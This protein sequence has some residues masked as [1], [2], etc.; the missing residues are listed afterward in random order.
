M[1][2]GI[3]AG[4]LWDTRES[5]AGH[6]RNDDVEGILRLPAERG[7]I[8]Q[9]ADDLQL[10]DDRPRPAVRDDER[11]RVLLFRAN[12]NEMNVQPVDLRDELWQGA[13]PGLALAPV[14]FAGPILR[15]VLHGL[16]L[17]ALRRVV[18]RL[19]FRPAGRLDA[20][21]K[22][23]QRLFRSLEMKRT[24]RIRPRQLVQIRC[25][26]AFGRLGG[27]GGRTLCVAGGNQK[28]DRDECACA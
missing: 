1:W 20:P 23:C 2:G 19:S 25:N 16:E 24:N 14:V 26:R 28:H 5:V 21:A 9:R 8:G 27:V 3:P 18:D 10:L 22:I 4:F 15:Q 12:V 7:G 6:R 17:H 11:Q 13:E